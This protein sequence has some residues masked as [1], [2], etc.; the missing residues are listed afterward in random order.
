M[1]PFRLCQIAIVLLLSLAAM[2]VFSEDVPAPRKPAVLFAVGYCD[3]FSLPD[4]TVFERLQA[5]GFEVGYSMQEELDEA[6]LSK[7][8]VVVLLGTMKCDNFALNDKVKNFHA[9]LASCSAK[10]G[11][12]FVNLR[13]GESPYGIL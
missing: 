4:A 9:A 6:R 1:T 11:G 8:N 10:G 13:G 3:G 12:I 7:F 5:A 2:R